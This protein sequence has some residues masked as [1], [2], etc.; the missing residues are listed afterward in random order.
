MECATLHEPMITTLLSYKFNIKTR[1]PPSFLLFIIMVTSYTRNQKCNIASFHHDNITLQT[2]ETRIMVANLH[3]ETQH[4]MTPLLQRCASVG[5]NCIV[6]GLT[7]FVFDH[8]GNYF[9]N[10][11]FMYEHHCKN[12]HP[13]TFWDRLLRLLGSIFNS[14]FK[15]S[16]NAPLLFKTCAA[17]LHLFRKIVD[18]TH[19]LINSYVYIYIYI[20]IC[21]YISDFLKS[22]H[23]TNILALLGSIF[24]NTRSYPFEN[25]E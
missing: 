12:R 10:N 15:R 14:F 21:I 24:G 22:F 4:R 5:R 11:R 9:V 20:Y 16:E 23:K 25:A 6:D 17:C 18:H 7:L 3:C 13:D 2:A 8:L 19:I 1:G